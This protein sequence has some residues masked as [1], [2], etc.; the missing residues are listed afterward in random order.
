MKVVNIDGACTL[1]AYKTGTAPTQPSEITG[2]GIAAH[3]PG[4]VE[5]DLMNAGLLPDI[6]KAANVEKTRAFELY[7]WWYVKNFE[8]DELPDDTDKFLV[9]DGVDTYAEYFLNGVKIGESDN[10]LIAHEFAVDHAVKAGV[11]RLAVHIFSTVKKSENFAVDPLMVADWECFAN[12]RC[13]KAAY[14][15]GW[16]IFPRVVSA[17][18]WRSVR[19]ECR[20]HVRIDRLLRAQK[21]V[22]RLRKTGA[23]DVGIYYER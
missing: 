1:Y 16:D 23:A 22:S 21:T 12:L 3:I 17:G 10:M 6:Y 8:V 9:F 15:Y 7:D 5:I 13:R 19:L 14:M 20:H 11:N 18:I 2:E 4:N